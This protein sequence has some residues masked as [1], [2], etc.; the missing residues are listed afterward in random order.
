[1]H[2][3]VEQIVGSRFTPRDSFCSEHLITDSTQTSKISSFGRVAFSLRLMVVLSI[4]HQPMLPICD[5]ST[6]IEGDA[7]T[8]LIMGLDV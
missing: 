4:L 8:Q 7:V 1:M 3:I 2:I 5:S 6:T